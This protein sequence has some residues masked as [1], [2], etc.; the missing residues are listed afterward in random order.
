LKV[1]NLDIK[2]EG[3]RLGYVMGA[4]DEFPGSPEPGYEV[5]E[6]S[7]EMIMN[8]DL[9]PFDAVVTGV[10]RMRPGRSS[11]KPR[12]N[13]FVTLKTAERWSFSTTCLGTRRHPDRALPADHRA[14]PVSVEARRSCSFRPNIPS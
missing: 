3:G 13:F 14:R 2:T 9:A 6:L 1:V 10:R 8:M 12:T 11:K 5:V 7:D 4:G